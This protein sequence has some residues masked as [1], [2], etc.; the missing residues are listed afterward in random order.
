[1]VHNR[2]RKTVNSPYLGSS[3]TD[4]HEVW[5]NDAYWSFKS[6]LPL[7]FRSFHDRRWRTAA[8]LKTVKSPYLGNSS[9]DFTKFAVV[10][11]IDSQPDWTERDTVCRRDSCVPKEPRIPCGAHWRLL[12]NTTEPSAAARGGQ[13]KNSWTDRDAGWGT[14]PSAQ[15]AMY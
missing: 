8:S 10:T 12:A 3:S 4:L 11:H 7:K 1:M 14:L 15:W 9:T 5:H 13:S 2:H 6:H